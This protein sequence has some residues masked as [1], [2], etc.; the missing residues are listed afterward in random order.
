VAVPVLA[1]SASLHER[2]LVLT[3]ANTHATEPVEAEIRIRGGSARN[4]RGRMLTG[5]DIHAHNTFA[6]PRAVEPRDV[7]I[8]VTTGANTHRFAPASVTRLELELG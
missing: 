1:G 3:V 5:P 6:E 7:E 4:G 8:G 2:R